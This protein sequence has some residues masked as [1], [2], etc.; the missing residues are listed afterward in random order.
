MIFLRPIKVYLPFV[1][2]VSKTSQIWKF[3]TI[4]EQNSL[5][6]IWYFLYFVNKD[7]Q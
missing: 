1:D 5:F 7:K 2:R 3:L 6:W 4:F